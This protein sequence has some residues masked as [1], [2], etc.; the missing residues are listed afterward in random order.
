MAFFSA[1]RAG[2]CLVLGSSGRRCDEYVIAID[3]DLV[4]RNRSCSRTLDYGAFFQVENRPME[5]A[6]QFAAL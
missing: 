2:R 6:D 5:D 3:L 1:G 4:A